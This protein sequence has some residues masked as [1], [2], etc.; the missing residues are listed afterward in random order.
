VEF[1]RSEAFRPLFAPRGLPRPAAGE[2][3]PNALQRRLPGQGGVQRFFTEHGRPFC[4]YVVLGSMRDARRLV[5]ELHRVLD[6][7]Q[8]GAG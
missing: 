7:L 4:L 2:F 8:V 3:G 1:E 5:P 6:A